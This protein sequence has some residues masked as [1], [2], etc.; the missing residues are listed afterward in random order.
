M[1]RLHAK[2]YGRVQGVYYR[3]WTQQTAASLNLTGWVR[4]L[5]EGQVEVLAEG[6]KAKLEALYQLCLQ[7]PSAAQVEKIEEK[8]LGATGEFEDFKVLR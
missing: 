5:P 3:A 1:F 7:G 6:E 8:W 2:I 4:N